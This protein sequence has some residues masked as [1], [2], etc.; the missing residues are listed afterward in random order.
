M[1]YEEVLYDVA[2]GIAT[3]TLNRPAQ[4]NALTQLMQ[5]ELRDAM[6]AADADDAVRVI[7]L[8]G[9]GRGFCAGADMN[10]LS[11][12]SDAGGEARNREDR[13][14]ANGLRRD[15]FPADFQQKSSYIPS[16]GK[17]VIAAINGPCA[18]LGF[19]FTL[20]CDL[21]FAAEGA[22]FTTAFSRRGLIAEHGVSWMLPRLIGIQNALDLLLSARKF[23][24]AEAEDLGLVSRVFPKETFMESVRDYATMLAKQVSPRSLR[25][26]KRQIYAAQFQNLAEAIEIGD[27]EMLLSF[28]SEDFKEGVDH[29]I[30]KREPQFTGR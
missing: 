10:L 9:A 16:V 4:L 29:F 18:G 20:Y 26:M 27:R 6:F 7:I 2:D 28:D 25:I 23:D 3:V 11:N 1:A 15:D 8:T 24:A 22:K 12:L 21:R 19:I 13:M 17:P 30:E 5:E 14:Q